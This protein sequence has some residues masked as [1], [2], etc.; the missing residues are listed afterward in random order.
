[1]KSITRVLA[2]HRKLG[3]V[4]TVGASV[5]VGLG[6]A[7]VD[8]AVVEAAVRFNVATALFTMSGI[9]LEWEAVRRA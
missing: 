3:V 9:I 6:A 1:M 7:I 5:G 4:A 8:D 2:Q